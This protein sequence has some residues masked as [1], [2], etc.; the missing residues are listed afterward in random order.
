MAKE[1][2]EGGGDLVPILVI[3]ALVVGAFIFKDQI[4][5][6]LNSAGASVSAAGGGGGGARGVADPYAHTRAGQEV[7]VDQL[8]S[9]IMA[10]I[11]APN[12]DRRRQR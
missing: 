4:I 10:K 3:G 11:D 8:V 1:K 9:K 12:V 5:G 7:Y 2:S 6:A